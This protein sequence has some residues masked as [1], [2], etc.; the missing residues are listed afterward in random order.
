MS[1]SFVAERP[2]ALDELPWIELDQALSEDAIHEFSA[3]ADRRI[4]QRNAPRGAVAVLAE[5]AVDEVEVEELAV[6][7]RLR[8]RDRAAYEDLRR[9]QDLPLIDDETDAEAYEEATSGYAPPLV[10]PTPHE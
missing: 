3:T 4:R 10:D 2:S 6:A 9:V 1:N 5:P 8:A 7:E